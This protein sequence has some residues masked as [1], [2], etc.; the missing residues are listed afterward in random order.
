MRY[1]ARRERFVKAM[2]LIRDN[3]S[4]STLPFLFFI[5]IKQTYLKQIES[6]Q[7]NPEKLITLI[8]VVVI[9]SNLISQFN[10]IF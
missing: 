7:I 2:R 10:T 9:I 6:P 8:V 1:L 4:G 3:W 5:L